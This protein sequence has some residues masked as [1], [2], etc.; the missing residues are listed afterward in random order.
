[1]PLLFFGSAKIGSEFVKNLSQNHPILFEKAKG[2]EIT[3]NMTSNQLKS[4]VKVT[5]N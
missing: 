3:D 2:V 5:L 1:M 4:W